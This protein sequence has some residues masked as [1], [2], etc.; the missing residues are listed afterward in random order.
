MAGRCARRGPS[1]QV[2][3]LLIVIPLAS[4]RICFQAR[5]GVLRE[6]KDDRG[7]AK[8]RKGSAMVAAVGSTSWR[9]NDDDRASIWGGLVPV[10]RQRLAMVVGL[11]HGGQRHP[12]RPRPQSCRNTAQVNPGSRPAP[13]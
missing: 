7:A 11:P 4:A 12:V 2:E 8:C 3:G 1:C 9:G 13:R 10:M 6:V 5:D